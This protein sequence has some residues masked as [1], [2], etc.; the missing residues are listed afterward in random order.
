MSGFPALPDIVPEYRSRNFAVR[1]LFQRR[2]EL[3]MELARLGADGALSILDV[4]CGEGR[5]LGLI[6]GRYLRHR[7][8]GIDHNP[9]V[10]TLSIP[11]VE[12]ACRDLKGP[13]DLGQ[14]VYDR[15][16]CLDVLEH[17]QDLRGPLAAVA[18]GLKPGGLFVVSAPSENV[19]HKLCRFLIKGTFSEKAGPASSPHYH[20]A[21]TLWRDIEGAGFEPLERRALPLP[22]PLALIE[23]GSFRRAGPR[24]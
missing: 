22:G 23:L 13:G 7:L 20:R 9:H 17:I 15:V 1:W 24:V 4:G 3:A 5:M 14:A 19:V 18:L 11:G 21:A 6:R 12:V 2:L 16:F 8:S 10:K